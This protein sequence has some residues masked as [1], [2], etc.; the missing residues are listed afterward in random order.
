MR[1]ASQSKTYSLLI[2]STWNIKKLKS[3]INYAFKEEVKANIINLFYGARL[4]SNENLNISS[5]FQERDAINQLIVSLKP[6]EN[7][8]KNENK[9]KTSIENPSETIKKENV[10]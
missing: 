10:K 2:P 9:S 8:L 5:I 1:F 7:L 4:L 6:K 3:F